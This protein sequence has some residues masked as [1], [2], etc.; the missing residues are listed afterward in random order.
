MAKPSPL[1]RFS[2][3]HHAVLPG[4]IHD[5]RDEL[6]GVIFK[7]TGP[8]MYHS[9]RFILNWQTPDQGRNFMWVMR[10]IG[11]NGN[12]CLWTYSNDWLFLVLG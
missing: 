4:C 9:G 3:D 10:V 6:V 11:N 2:W 7:Q 1:L 12:E 8:D 5:F